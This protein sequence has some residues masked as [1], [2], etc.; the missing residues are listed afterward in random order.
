MMAAGAPAFDLVL[1]QHLRACRVQRGLTQED[2]A[3]QIGVTFQQVQKYE[4]GRNRLSVHR[5]VLA[6]EA[7]GRSPDLMLREAVDCWQAGIEALAAAGT[8]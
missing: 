8:G 2:L 5:L 1:G 6:A 4:A 3:R 7:L